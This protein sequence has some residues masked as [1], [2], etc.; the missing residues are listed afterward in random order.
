M[1]EPTKSAHSKRPTKE[2]W[3]QRYVRLIKETPASETELTP[4]PLEDL[5]AIQD[6]IDAG[7]LRGLAIEDASVGH[8]TG[9]IVQGPTLL[10]RIFAEEQLEHIKSKS[11]W[12]RLKSGSTIFIGWLS[13]IISAV[14]IY[15]L[16]KK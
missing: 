15:Y 7:Y 16:T 13:G 1:S 11:F 10:V 12:G 9:A 8:V 6:L 2:S 3:R 5:Q 14:I 4:E